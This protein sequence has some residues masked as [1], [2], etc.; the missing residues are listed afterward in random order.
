M[1]SVK[2]DK[3]KLLNKVKENREQHRNL[4]L[5]AQE[6]YRA[7]VIKE[8]DAMLAEARDGKPIRR[9]IML[10]E[11]VDHTK[12]YDRVVAMLEMSVD[13]IIELSSQEFEE[14]VLDNWNWSQLAML[15]NSRYV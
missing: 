4:F 1:Q 6:G 7:L 12:D 2:I 9:A 15:T 3:V 8:L 10:P 14:Y 13:A 11:P 5:K